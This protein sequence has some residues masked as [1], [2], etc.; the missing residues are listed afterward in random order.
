MK[1]DLVTTQTW[2]AYDRAIQHLVAQRRFLNAGDL[3]AAAQRAIP[4][5]RDIATVDQHRDVIPLRLREA[6]WRI[7]CQVLD[8]MNARIAER[9]MARTDSRDV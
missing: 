1:L 5:Q 3:H 2:N 6:M 9:Q 4:C 7:S 8:M